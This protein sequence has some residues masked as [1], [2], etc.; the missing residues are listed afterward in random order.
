[1]MRED[2]V[3]QGPQIRRLA[4]GEI[5]Y[6]FYRR[7]ARALRRAAIGEFFT[8]GVRMLADG[9][10]KATTTAAESAASRRAWCNHLDD[11]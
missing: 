5:D 10:G 6:E 2:P 3:D 7:R 8:L 11:T 4:G 1:M 9:P